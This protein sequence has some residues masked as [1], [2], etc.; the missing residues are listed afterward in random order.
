MPEFSA[1]IAHE[2]LLAIG[3]VEDRMLILVDIDKLMTGTEMGLFEPT[4]Q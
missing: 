3:T 1:A 4:L 2:H